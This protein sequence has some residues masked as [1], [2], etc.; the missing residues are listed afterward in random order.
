MCG[1]SFGR[2]V[3]YAIPNSSLLDDLIQRGKLAACHYH[4]K[5]TSELKKTQQLLLLAFLL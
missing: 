1:D 2:E 5:G 4:K 3:D